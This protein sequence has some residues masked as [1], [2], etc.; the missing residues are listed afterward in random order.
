MVGKGEE[1]KV[2]AATSDGELLGVKIDEPPAEAPLLKHPSSFFMSSRFTFT[3]VSWDSTFLSI[4]EADSS[5]N[6][7]SSFLL[8][9]LASCLF[10]SKLFDIF[11]FEIETLVRLVWFGYQHSQSPKVG[12]KL[13]V[14]TYSYFL[15]VSSFID[16]VVLWISCISH[17]PLCYL[18]FIPLLC[19]MWW[20]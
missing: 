5:W 7:L 11:N 12:I 17:F 19:R 16:F 2:G 13:P 14:N 4:G 8:K 6:L 20:W 3:S 9:F 18:S 10:N 1:S 15:S